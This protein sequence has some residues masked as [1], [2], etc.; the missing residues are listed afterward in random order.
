MLFRLKLILSS[1]EGLAVFRQKQI[2]RSTSHKKL[3]KQNN[4]NFFIQV[5]YGWLHLTN[6]NFPGHMSIEEIIDQHISLNQHT[7]LDFSSDV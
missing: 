3:Q 7:R 4:E 6:K 2:I 1:H 5:L